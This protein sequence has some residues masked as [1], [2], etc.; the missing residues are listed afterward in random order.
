MNLEETVGGSYAIWCSVAVTV[1]S[2]V[3]VRYIIDKVRVT[4]DQ[5]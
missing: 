3:K 5:G 4:L 2:E 1:T